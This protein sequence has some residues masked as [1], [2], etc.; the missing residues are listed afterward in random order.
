MKAKR[1]YLFIIISLVLLNG[2]T[3]FYLWKQN[4]HPPH[5]GRPKSLVLVLGLEGNAKTKVL[6]LEK[7]HFKDKSA[8]VHKSMRL[9]KQLHQGFLK[10]KNDS[11]QST[12]LIAKIVENQRE[13]EQM[14]LDYFQ[15]VSKYCNPQQKLKLK[16]AIG[17]AI[18]QMSAGPK[19]KP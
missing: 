7:I 17:F 12:Q 14:T 3:L 9:H 5:G 8:L 1:F 10:S 19:R 16:K 11:V 15:E 6:A 4:A 2:F 18:Q 13:M